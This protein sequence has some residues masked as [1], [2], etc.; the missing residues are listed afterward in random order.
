[1]NAFEPSPAPA[2]LAAAWTV[3]ADLSWPELADLASSPRT[4]PA[5]RRHA[6]DAIAARIGAMSLGER[7]ALARRATRRIVALLRNS[8]E[9]GV[10]RALLTNPRF[11]EPDATAIAARPETPVV[12]LDLLRTHGTWSDRPGIR[13][14]LLNNPGAPAVKATDLG[15][16][17]DGEGPAGTNDTR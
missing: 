12:V 8:N 17:S 7:I 1:M 10:L 14:A 15:N 11:T 2:P 9:P 3:L 4:H 5:V 6:E 16:K 13:S